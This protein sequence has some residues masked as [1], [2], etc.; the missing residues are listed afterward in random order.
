MRYE[1]TIKK[2]KEK[3]KSRTGTREWDFFESA[4]E[5]AWYNLPGGTTVPIYAKVLDA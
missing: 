2:K 3:K 5:R 4:R 1:I